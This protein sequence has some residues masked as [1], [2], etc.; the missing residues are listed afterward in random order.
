[1]RILASWAGVIP[2]ETAA[3]RSGT[4]CCRGAE[5]L[6]AGELVGPAVGPE[7]GTVCGTPDE[8]WEEGAPPAG[9]ATAALAAWTAD[10]AMPADSTAVAAAVR[11]TRR[12]DN[13]STMYMTI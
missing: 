1:L 12:S 5:P 10:P 7:V 2:P 4:N 9:D 13:D 3:M 6:D 11:A 8:T